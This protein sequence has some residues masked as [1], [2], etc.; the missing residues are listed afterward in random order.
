MDR[1]AVS[2]KGVVDTLRM[3]IKKI[4]ADIKAS[5]KSK[6][7]FERHLGLL[8]VRKQ[9][10]ERRVSHNSDWIKTY[11]LEVGPFA[12]KYDKMAVELGVIYQK[13]KKGHAQGIVL[14][15]N[16]FGYHP[17]FKRPQ[18]TFTASAWRPMA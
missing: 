13:A 10:L 5:T 17:A 12:E 4:D 6:L 18:D 7:E 9:E 14:L 8:Q 3:Q 11:D 1:T 16:E 15:E 2:I